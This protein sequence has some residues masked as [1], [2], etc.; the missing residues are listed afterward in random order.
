MIFGRRVFALCLL[1][2][3][4][5][6]QAQAVWGL[7]QLMQALAQTRAATAR[8]TQTETAPV[9]SAPLL[10]AGTLTYVAPDYL[11][12]VTLSPAP[13]A[14]VLDHGEVTV[15]GGTAGTHKFAVGQDPRIAGLVEGIRATLAGDLPGLQR[16]YRVTL[17]GGAAGWQLQMA[18]NGAAL[19]RFLRSMTIAGV[20]GHVDAIDTVGSDGSETRMSIQAPHAP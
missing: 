8:F 2:A 6:A 7:P 13:E 9:L 11:R 5:G 20:A 16:Y 12:K 1:A 17:S 3:A 15:S 4:P 18:P 19:A 10:S 14:F